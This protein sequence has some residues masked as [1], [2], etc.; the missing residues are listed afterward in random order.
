MTTAYP[1]SVGVVHD[2]GDRRKLS[3]EVRAEDGQLADPGALVFV[4]KEPDGALTSYTLDDGVVRES[5]GVFYVHWDCVKVG[6]HRYRFA[7]SGD[8]A[9]AQ[10]AS[11]H[12]QRSRVLT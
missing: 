1:G 4:M 7:A 12:V 2:V 3:A 8:V 10:E 9:A 11:F 6:V 5:V